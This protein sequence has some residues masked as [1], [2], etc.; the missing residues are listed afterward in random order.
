MAGQRT[1]NAFLAL[2]TIVATLLSQNTVL[3]D[4]AEIAFDIESQELG[5]ALSEFA[6]QSGKE[7]LFVEAD[8]AG[9]AARGISGRYAPTAALELLLADSNLDY[10]VSALDT[11]LVG[12][13]AGTEGGDSDS[14]NGRTAG[15]TPRPVIMAQAAE[16]S[17]T[18]QERETEAKKQKE[19]LPI[20]EIVVTGTN[21]RGIE[22]G[23]S[24]TMVFSLAE[25][26]AA[27]VTNV[28]ELFE[29]LPQ[30]FGGGPGQDTNFTQGVSLNLGFV[31]SINLR[32]LGPQATLVLLNG[33]RL[34]AASL[35]ET[36][37]VSAIPLSAIERVEVV[38]DGAS[39]IYGSDAVAGV[40]NIILRDD[41]DGADT[42]L[43]FGSPTDGGYE[44]YQASQSI[45]QTWSTGNFTAIYD[46]NKRTNLDAQERDFTAAAP[47]FFDLAP[48]H[49]R[50]SVVTSARQQ[51]NASNRIFFDALYTDRS[52]AFR[53][54][55]GTSR[56]INFAD[57]S[58]V[59]AVAGLETSLSQRFY[60]TNYGQFGRVKTQRDRLNV[61]TGLNDF[62]SPTTSTLW[63]GESQISG[64]LLEISGGTI[65]AATG[66]FYRN[67]EFISV[68]GGNVE[69]GGKRDIW[70]AYGELFL[71]FVGEANS[72]PAISRLE[73]TAAVRYEK[74]SDFGSVTNPKF[75]TLWGLS[76][77]ITIRATY[78][79]SFRAPTL[80]Q[81]DDFNF[82]PLFATLPEQD[83]SLT[84][85]V[86]LLGNNA[87]LGP[88]SADTWSV[89]TIV[90]PPFIDGLSVEVSYFEISYSERIATAS[91]SSFGMLSQPDVFSSVITRDP[92]PS[93]IGEL[94]ALPTA[95]DFIGG[96]D[97]ED[98]EVIVDNRIQNI[99]VANI[100]GIDATV[101]YHR[102]SGSNSF[103]LHAN[104]SYIDELLN[105]ITPEARSIEAI[106]KISNPVDLRFRG[107]VSWSRN[108][109]SVNSFINYVDGYTNDL[110]TPNEHVDPWTTVDISLSY[111][112]SQFSSENFLEGLV[113]SASV[114]NLFNEDPPLVNVSADPRGRSYDPTNAN[115]YGRIAAIQLRKSW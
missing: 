77:W 31:T 108:G 75:G 104:V 91:T 2:A 83:G 1:G 79:E 38:T 5:A 27:G 14:G 67:E 85:S 109:I 99:G 95:F 90:N 49:E 62:S 55:V 57:V 88:E 32:G 47:D 102:E 87:D 94:A 68:T 81:L 35:G 43:R 64:D 30:N 7:L 54:T 80:Q 113:L 110:V 72:L 56:R 8:V 34:P 86:I 100:S 44:E 71:P 29:R 51:L 52:S 37:D 36:V 13:A 105:R 48:D 82:T 97:P 15:A 112:F 3:A 22:D 73:M 11:V 70:G 114:Q 107:G 4:E 61:D 26:E 40:V 42:Q 76:D 93:L 18:P 19:K 115:A 106:N 92:A 58:Q 69:T 60:W 25:I 50:H 84:P 33:R 103:D 24:P 28:D 89:G 17:Q 46:Y 45:G 41:Y 23:P 12:E 53:D 10:R 6:L 20:E 96:F 59:T 78:S 66:L 16:R 74:Y 63:S 111:D 9:K 101:R 98:I 21:I 65:K 39:A